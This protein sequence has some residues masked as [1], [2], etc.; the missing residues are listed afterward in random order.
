[1]GSFRSWWNSL[2]EPSPICAYKRETRCST[3][4]DRPFLERLFRARRGRSPHENA[5]GSPVHEREQLQLH[6]YV[7]LILI[8]EFL[9]ELSENLAAPAVPLSSSL[10]H[11]DT[12]RPQYSTKT[13]RY[14]KDSKNNYFSPPTEDSKNNYYVPQ[15]R[16][17]RTTTTTPPTNRFVL[18]FPP[19]SSSRLVHTED[20]PRHCWSP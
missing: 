10:L 12:P 2:C 6:E 3:G 11:Q 4:E 17:P 9:H 8:L 1:M 19:D 15:R 16:T 7:K 5:R 13:S 18:F 20:P 14:S